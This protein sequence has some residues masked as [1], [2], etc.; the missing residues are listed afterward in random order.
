MG[1]KH[2]LDNPNRKSAEFFRKIIRQA[3]FAA[4]KNP[5]KSL[6][7]RKNR[8]QLKVRELEKNKGVPKPGE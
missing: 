7:S 6:F 1:F 8:L 2:L 3:E 4:A 5:R